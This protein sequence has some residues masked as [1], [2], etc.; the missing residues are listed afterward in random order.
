MFS[1]NQNVHDR[2][3]RAPQV[4]YLRAARYNIGSQ[5]QHSRVRNQSRDGSQ[6][7]DLFTGQEE[8]GVCLRV[9]S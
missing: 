7:G 6:Q 5:R 1:A 2:E 4:H 9:E 3:Q 8:R